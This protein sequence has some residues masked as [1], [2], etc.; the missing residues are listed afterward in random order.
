[1]TIDCSHC[2]MPFDPGEEHTVVAC[3]YCKHRTFNPFVEGFG[4][5]LDDEDD[6]Q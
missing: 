6:E 3:P 2:G 5:E 1:M 4:D